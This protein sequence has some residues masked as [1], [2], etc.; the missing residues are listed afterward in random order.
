MAI[1]SNVLINACASARNCVASSPQAA[2]HSGYE[3]PGHD[4]DSNI[5]TLIAGLALVCLCLG[6]GA[7]LCCAL[8]R[9]PDQH[10]LR[11]I[12]PARLRSTC[13][14]GKSFKA[15]SIGAD[16]ALCVGRRVSKS[17]TTS[18]S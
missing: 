14:V 16:L 3:R 8:H 10:V 4:S 18:F 9:Y 6:F 15:V 12:L 7:R 5:S 11:R 13:T 2:I 1:D 17:L